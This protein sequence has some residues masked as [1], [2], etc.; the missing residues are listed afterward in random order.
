MKKLLTLVLGG[1][2]FMGSNA[3]NCP[4]GSMFSS[5]LQTCD[6]GLFNR[7]DAAGNI[8]VRS[9]GSIS[10]NPTSNSGSLRYSSVGSSNGIG[11]SFTQPIGIGISGSAIASVNPGSPGSFAMAQGG[12]GVGIPGRSGLA[13]SESSNYESA[14]FVPNNSI[15]GNA[16]IVGSSSSGGDVQ[17]YNAIQN[18]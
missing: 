16:S 4:Q 17:T 15:S 12:Q 13:F 3:S 10:T 7:Y 1:S 11:S 5:A 14:A 18:S 6:C 9:T 8:C 2:L